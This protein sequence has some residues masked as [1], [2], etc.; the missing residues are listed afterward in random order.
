MHST[1]EHIE[2]L[3]ATAG[4]L[5]ET[6]IELVK[7]KAAGKLSASLSGFFTLIIML[8]LTGVTLTVISFG[9]AYLIGNALG[10]LSTGFFIMGAVYV[11]GGLLLY[12]N[13]KKWVQEPLSNLFINKIMNG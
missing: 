3:I 4:E 9:C 1:V 5:A 10:S 12:F 7:L 8:L 6:K 13:R 11:A 2:K